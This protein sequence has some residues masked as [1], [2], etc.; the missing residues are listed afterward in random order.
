MGLRITL[1]L[2][3]K[4]GSELIQWSTVI[5]AS[6]IALVIDVKSRRIPNLLCG[7]LLLL[8]LIWSVWQGGFAGLAEALAAMALLA[9]PFISLF[10]FAGG[11][12]GDAKLM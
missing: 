11:G 5:G 3:V 4:N 1:L 10:L 8:G 2:D 12:A 7:S 9:L 6:L